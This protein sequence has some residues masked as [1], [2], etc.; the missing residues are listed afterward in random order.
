MSNVLTLNQP[1]VNVGLVTCTCT[2]PAT[3][4]GGYVAGGLF[5]V[6]VQYTVPEALATGTGAGSGKGLGSGAGGGAEGFTDGDLGPGFGGVGQGF[7][8][9]NGYQQPAID[10]KSNPQ[11]P[12]VSSALEITVVNTTQS[13][14]YYTST[15]PSPTQSAEQFTVV[16]SPAIGDVITITLSSSNASDKVLIGVISQISCSQGMN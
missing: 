16:F 7:G 3:V 11:G 4:A 13:V 6:K 14:T 10:I 8:V 2:I 12:S 1:Q 9:G 15:I 5:N